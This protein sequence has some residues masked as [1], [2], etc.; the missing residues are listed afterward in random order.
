MEVTWHFRVCLRLREVDN[1]TVRKLQWSQPIIFHHVMQPWRCHWWYFPVMDLLNAKSL[2][3]LKENR[4]ERNIVWV[5]AIL[6]GY[7][8]YLVKYSKLSDSSVLG[9]KYTDNIISILE[10]LLLNFRRAFF[11]WIYCFPSLLHL[12]LQEY[13]APRKFI[14]SPGKCVLSCSTRKKYTQRNKALEPHNCRGALFLQAI[15]LAM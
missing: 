15:Y 10:A 13:F 3:C 9:K 5:F 6:R 12:R 8:V 4:H 1:D 7:W 14:S 2:K 11:I